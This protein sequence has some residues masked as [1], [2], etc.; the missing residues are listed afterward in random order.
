[1]PPKLAWLTEPRHPAGAALNQGAGW[2][3]GVKDRTNQEDE[4]GV[5]VS[6]RTDQ[7][8]LI[9]DDEPENVRLL[10]RLLTASGYSEV[11][12]TSDPRQAVM[13]YRESG[14]DLVMLDLHMPVLD[15][16]GVIEELRRVVPQK[17]LAPILVLTSDGDQS[18]K[19]RALAAGARDFLAKPFDQT[20][21]V[22]RVRSLLDARA[23]DLQLRRTGGSGSNGGASPETLR[24]EVALLQDKHK[25][26]RLAQEETVH[27]LALAAELRDDETSRHLERM[28]RYCWVIGAALGLDEERCETIRMAS[29]M[30]D[31]GKICV[32][33]SIRLKPGRLTADE[34]KTMK[35]HAQIGYEI[36]AGST[37][38][39]TTI[40][41]TIAWTH[42]EKV[43]GSGYPRRLMGDEIP[44]EGQIAAVADVFD[45]LTTDRIYRKGFTLPEALNVMREGRR[46]H[47]D[48]K[49]LDVFFDRIDEIVAVKQKL[50]D[51]ASRFVGRLATQQPAA[52]ARA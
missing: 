41:A 27:R 19:Q 47:F 22:A 49:I 24:N 51:A 33:D 31:I 48:G 21:V 12:S 25:D 45:A 42:H 4:L 17:D 23:L 39:L 13:L 38:E 36:L 11:Q 52:R 14:P 46:A 37:S 1:M 29:K 28:S 35:T 26:L 34:F 2:V 3:D 43:D 9:V 8:I 40:A 30:H 16:F 32:P 50:D 15:A 7:T 6:E 10:E 18:S 20:E 5:T 44:L